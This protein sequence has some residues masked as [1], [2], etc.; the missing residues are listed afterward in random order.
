V[1]TDASFPHRAMLTTEIQQLLLKYYYS[2]HQKVYASFVNAHF[3]VAVNEAR[4][5]LE[6]SIFRSNA[7]FDR[8]L[9]YYQELEKFTQLAHDFNP[10]K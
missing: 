2:A 4:N 3:Y 8:I 6:A 9:E 10:S 1:Y 5:L 7:K